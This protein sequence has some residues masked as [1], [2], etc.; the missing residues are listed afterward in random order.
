MGIGKREPNGKKI[1]ELRKQQGLPQKTLAGKA[2]KMSE[3]LLRDIER[4]NKPVSATY[5]TAIATA[6]GVPPDEITLSPTPDKT[7]DASASCSS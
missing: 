2:D 7:S 4:K 1:A 5:I 6:L 3:R